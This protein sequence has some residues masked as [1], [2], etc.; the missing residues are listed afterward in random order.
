MKSLKSGIMECKDDPDD[1]PWTGGDKEV[2][3]VGGDKFVL[4]GDFETS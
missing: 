4:E 1:S 2:L 3:G